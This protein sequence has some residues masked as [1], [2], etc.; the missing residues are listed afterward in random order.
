[1]AT[2][3]E[4]YTGPIIGGEGLKD[5]PLRNTRTGA[6]ATSDAHGRFHEAVVRGNVYFLST[7]NAAVT[8]YV[9]AAAGTPLL[10]IHNPANSGKVAS[11]LAVAFSPRVEATAAAPSD[12]S[13][14]TGPSV[15]PTGTITVPTNNFSQLNSGSS[16]VGFVNTALTGSTALK[17]ALPLFRY[18]WITGAGAYQAPAFADVGG[19]LIAAPGNEIA[20]GAAATGTSLTVNISMFWEEIPL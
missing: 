5:G 4:L 17:L 15:L 14:W 20:V 19:L 2:E 10:A 12:V 9:G 18:A 8:G 3:L 11:L 7:A 6:L 16:M 1:M 13:A